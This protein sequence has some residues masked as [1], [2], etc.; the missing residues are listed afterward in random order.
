MYLRDK[1]LTQLETANSTTDKAQR[2]AALTF[3]VVGAGY[4]GAELTAQM[5]RLTTNLL[6]LY[7]HVSPDDI[8]WLL[9]DVADAVMP[10]LGSSLGESALQLLRRRRVDVRLGV[11]VAAVSDT[12]VSLTDGTTLDC[13]TLIWC[14]GRHRQPVDRSLGLPMS[15]G[16]LAVDTY[17]RVPGHPE[18]YSIGDAAAVPDLTK[19]VDWTKTVNFPYVHRPPNTPC[20]KPPPPPTTSAPTWGTAPPR[21][22]G[23]TTSAWSS[24][25]AAPTPPPHHYTCICV[26]DLPKSSPWDTTCT[27]CPRSNDASE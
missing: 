13:S 16:R 8:Q 21:P 18:T 12:Q 14:A 22:T 7:P 17:L 10:E 4:A 25:S 15:K 11:S 1:V 19:P 3:V 26:D 2:R 23:T 24:T 6:P 20:G 9:V 5:A 27:P